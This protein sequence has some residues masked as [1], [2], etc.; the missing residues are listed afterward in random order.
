MAAT[1]EEAIT[2]FLDNAGIIPLKQGEGGV[3]GEAA[4]TTSSG[5]ATATGVGRPFLLSVVR[6][7]S[8]GVRG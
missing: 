7:F 1:L 6:L 2:V 8:L 5:E 3:G 4:A